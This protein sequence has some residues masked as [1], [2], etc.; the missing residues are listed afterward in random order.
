MPLF[1]NIVKFYDSR[2]GAVVIRTWTDILK[3]GHGVR[4][5]FNGLFK[6]F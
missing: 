6:I 5:I 1:S 3:C 4:D 2:V